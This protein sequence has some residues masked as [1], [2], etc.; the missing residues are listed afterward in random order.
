VKKPTSNFKKK[1][2]VAIE[3]QINHIAKLD[4]ISEIVGKRTKIED[5]GL[6]VEVGFGWLA[7]N[8][9]FKGGNEAV[10]LYLLWAG[11]EG[12]QAGLDKMFPPTP[13]YEFKLESL[14]LKN[15]LDERVAF[16][17]GA[18]D[19]T[20]IRWTAEVIEEGIKN[21]MTNSQIVRFLKSKAS[22][23]A[24]ERADVIT[25][26]ELVTAMNIVELETFKRNGVNR[27]KWITSLDERVCVQ[28]VGNEEAG[29]IPLG[30]NFPMGA[31]APPQH[32]RCRCYLVPI[33]PEVVEGSIW[34]GK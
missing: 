21:G 9:T 2:K 27:I 17:N 33:L 31:I 16:L 7:F 19:K 15:K 20:G 10:L 12:G 4:K 28:C 11:A 13:S 26:T 24:T 30:D 25:E 23:I 3:K 18:L 32:I 34:T 8:D 1:V 29:A 22:V 6:I 14:E 5:E